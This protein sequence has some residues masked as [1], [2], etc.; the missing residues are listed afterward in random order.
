MAFRMYFHNLA[1]LLL[2]AKFGDRG[3]DARGSFYNP[4]FMEMHK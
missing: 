4:T 2:L 1:R 3:R